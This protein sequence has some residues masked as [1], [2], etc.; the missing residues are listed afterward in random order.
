MHVPPLGMHEPPELDPELPPPLLPP[1]DEP[2]EPPLDDPPQR[3]LPGMDWGLK[4]QSPSLVH[5]PP[6]HS[7]PVPADPHGVPL[8]RQQVPS[9]AVSEIEQIVPAHLPAQPPFVHDWSAS[10]QP[11]PPGA[12]GE[13]HSLVAVLAPRCRLSCPVSVPETPAVPPADPPGGRERRSREDEA[14][15][16]RAPESH[17]PAGRGERQGHGPRGAAARGVVAHRRTVGRRLHREHDRPR[18]ETE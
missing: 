2:L 12:M 6:Q 3:G 18:G 17:R 1:D 15:L 13:R 10:T 8:G 14:D 9:I 11:V 4:S 5:M 16:R 7:G